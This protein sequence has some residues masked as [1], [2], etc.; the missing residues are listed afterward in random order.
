LRIES[1]E[2]NDTGSRWSLPISVFSPAVLNGHE[3]HLL[4]IVGLE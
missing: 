2:V 1:Q 4:F 3:H